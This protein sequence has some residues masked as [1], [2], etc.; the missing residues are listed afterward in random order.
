M[1]A[2]TIGK[3][4]SM[5]RFVE[6]LL[7]RFEQ[8]ITVDKHIDLVNRFLYGIGELEARIQNNSSPIAMALRNAIPGIARFC[9]SH[10]YQLSAISYQ[11]SASKM[12][13]VAGLR[14]IE[15][16]GRFETSQ[17][18]QLIQLNCLG[19]GI[20]K[21]GEFWLG[22]QLKELSKGSSW[23]GSDRQIAR[24]RALLAFI[25]C[26]LKSGAIRVEDATDI[27]T[28][29]IE[30]LPP[31]DWFSSAGAFYGTSYV[32]RTFLA[33]RNCPGVFADYARDVSERLLR[34]VEVRRRRALRFR[35]ESVPVDASYLL[36]RIRFT[37]SILDAAD[38]YC[39]ARY[40]NAALK[41]NDWHY[42]SVR[43]M[44]VPSKLTPERAVDLMTILHYIVSIANQERL[45][46]KLPKG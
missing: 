8:G 39:D 19:E 22:S 41:A 14:D 9:S 2:R 26:G 12:I 23:K 13:D 10:L 16:K 28:S 35:T 43:R 25:F 30:N 18:M 29:I 6:A 44:K 34:H 11:Q 21:N 32:L 4:S 36:E 38:L 27:L 45:W 7:D 1:L 33:L 37:L 46:G 20:G 15:E 3:D 31:K 5:R 40:L 24:S 17:E 42:G